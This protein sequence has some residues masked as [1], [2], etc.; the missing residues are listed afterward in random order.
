MLRAKAIQFKTRIADQSLRDAQLSS[1]DRNGKLATI[2]VVVK[3]VNASAFKIASP[4][5]WRP[6]RDYIERLGFPLLPKGRSM[7]QCGKSGSVNRS[8]PPSP[9][10][11]AVFFH[12]LCEIQQAGNWTTLLKILRH[13]GIEPQFIQQESCCGMPKLELGDLKY[14][15]TPRE[16]HSSTRGIGRNQGFLIVSPIPLAP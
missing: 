2:P 11:V 10:K 6:L 5:H 8:R 12:L 1:T 14:R 9:L 7:D 3:F 15:R 4:D 16:E 13:A